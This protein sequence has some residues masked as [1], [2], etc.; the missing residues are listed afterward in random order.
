M[1]TKK[2]RNCICIH[3]LFAMVLSDCVPSTPCNVG[4]MCLS[5][6]NP[7]LN[8][9][10]KIESRDRKRTGKKNPYFDALE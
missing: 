3:V 8:A 6:E 1:F 10:V 9:K 2:K 5:N 7:A 4:V